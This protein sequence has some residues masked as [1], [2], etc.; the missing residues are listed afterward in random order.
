[1]LNKE[2]LSE[3]M[4]CAI[5]TN[6][7]GN[8]M[9]IHDQ[10]L[11]STVQWLELDTINN[12]LF[13]VYEDGDMQDFGYPIEADVLKNIKAGQSV[14]LAYFTEGKIESKTQTSFIFRDV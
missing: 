9:V 14:E 13:L 12:K 5:L 2:N 1:M 11:H 7:T 6:S 4:R 8:I 10:P 3:K